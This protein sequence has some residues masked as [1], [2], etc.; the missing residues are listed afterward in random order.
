MAERKSISGMSDDEAQEFHVYYMQGLVGF[1]AVA[2]IA[3]A[4]V[5]A[6]RPW[7]T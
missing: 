6:W 5:W 3:H 2:V 4:L 1:T 7:I